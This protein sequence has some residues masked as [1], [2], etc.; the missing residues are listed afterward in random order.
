MSND[1]PVNIQDYTIEVL[2]SNESLSINE[3][4]DDRIVI[5]DG[6][7]KEIIIF[8]S[9]DYL[10]VVTEQKGDQGLQG[11][12]GLRGFRGVQGIRGPAGPIGPQG[13]RGFRG[14]MGF[15]GMQGGTGPIGP[16][17]P[18]GEIDSELL[19]ELA[20]PII[21]EAIRVPIDEIKEQIEAFPESIRNEIIGDLVGEDADI[22]WYTGDEEGTFVGQVSITSMI[23]E[24]YYQSYKSASSIIASIALDGI[25]DVAF[26]AIRQEMEVI[27]EQTRVVAESATILVAEIDGRIALVE[28][29]VSA[30]V[31]EIEAISSEVTAYQVLFNDSLVSVNNYIDAVASDGSATANSLNQYIVS[32]NNTVALLEQNLNITA[33]ELNAVVSSTNTL[34]LSVDGMEADIQDLYTLSG[35][36]V[37]GLLEANYQLKAQVRSDDTVVMAGIA[38]GASIGGD[39]GARSEIIFMA[40]TFAFV[41][42]MDGVIHAPFIFDAV[43]DTAYLRQAMIGN[44]TI[45]NAMITDAAI[46]NAKIDNGSITTAKIADA[47]ITTAKIANAQITNA[48][49][50]D[51]AVDTI[52]IAG[53]AVTIPAASVIAGS[54]NPTAGV[55][56]TVNTI[57]ITSF[58]AQIFVNAFLTA[59]AISSNFNTQ[60]FGIQTRLLCTSTGVVTASKVQAF[61][62]DFNGTDVDINIA[63]L[64][65]RGVGTAT[66]VLQVNT[67]Q[68]SIKS[69]YMQLLE[70][71]R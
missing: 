44:A 52:K 19:Q 51:L 53:N 68:V 69:R 34:S 54:V 67:N 21:N 26:A 27:A 20:E 66:F 35:D 40:D 28:N 3:F 60:K 11:V 15:G 59:S 23:N 57:S 65:T 42:K 47:Q 45:T 4:N 5:A 64:Y 62:A 7:E 30:S 39:L 14:A 41:T 56:F 36:S 10:E 1:F 31:T 24:S 38:L 25:D 63:S 17:G 55:W 29:T 70:V 8:G 37:T 46:T 18:P 22:D 71:K 49:I 61:M 48:K 43:N 16:I 12:R 58:G 13:N 50:G 2:N 33:T 6:T 32:N 9:S